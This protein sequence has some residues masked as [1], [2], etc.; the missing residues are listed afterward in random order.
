MT[1]AGKVALVTGGAKRVGRAIALEL[2]EAGCD[3]AVHYH[4]SVTEAE[5]VADAIR[6]L[7]RRCTLH[8][9]D[10]GDHESAALLV[11]DTVRCMGRLDIL[12][13]NASLFRIDEGDSLDTFDPVRWER[14]LGI[15]LIAPAALCHHAAGHL[16]S[17][18]EGKIINL[19]DISADRP[20]PEHLAYC[21]SK[22]GLV[23]LTKSL[24]RA[25]APA[26]QVNGVAPGLAEFATDHSRSV[27]DRLVRR[28]PAGRVGTPS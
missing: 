7:G 4:R 13:N 6:N 26:I 1:L 25:L 12:V 20:W 10:L 14:M 27:R 21:A 2:S 28:V 24:A 11:E 9:A 16:R 18:G 3:L 23:N 5:S 22:A 19:C 17:H 15:N 8:V